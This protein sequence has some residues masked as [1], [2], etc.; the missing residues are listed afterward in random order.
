[1]WL[2]IIFILFFVF[3]IFVIFYIYMLLYEGS[4]FILIID[5]MKFLFISIFLNFGVFFKVL[6]GVISIVVLIWK[7]K[8]L[9]LFVL[10]VL[11]MMWCVYVMCKNC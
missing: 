11:I 8:G 6:F 10:F 9:L 7:M 4:Y 1:M 3:L 2:I 5:L